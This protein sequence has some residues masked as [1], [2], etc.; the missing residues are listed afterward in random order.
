MAYI[1]YD[2]CFANCI[3]ICQIVSNNQNQIEYICKA[4]SQY[5]LFWWF[6]ILPLCEPIIF[7][8]IYFCCCYGQRDKNEQSVQVGTTIIPAQ[9]QQNGPTKV[10]Q[11]VS[12]VVP[13]GQ[14]VTLQ[15]GQVGV[16]VSQP[17]YQQQMQQM[18]E[19]QDVQ[20]PNLVQ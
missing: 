6:L 1:D 18:D 14:Q 3:G 5:S 13:Q 9:N 20:M 2:A 17:I 19:K 10:N 11:N 7:V 8:L 16:F 15:N 4:K 12:V